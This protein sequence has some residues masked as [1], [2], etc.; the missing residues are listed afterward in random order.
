M[1]RLP[2]DAGGRSIP[3]AAAASGGIGN[4]PAHKPLQVKAPVEHRRLLHGHNV[5]RGAV[6]EGADAARHHCPENHH[7]A[8]EGGSRPLPLP[9]NNTHCPQSSSALTPKGTK[10]RQERL[11][12]PTHGGKRSQFRA[13]RA[14]P[15]L[16]AAH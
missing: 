9:P 4:F 15:G 14:L 5:H 16:Q 1:P 13:K 6:L 10:N 2:E 8:Q 7:R 11:V 3:S 12:S